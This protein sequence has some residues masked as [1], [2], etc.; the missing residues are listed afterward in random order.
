MRAAKAKDRKKSWDG[1]NRDRIKQTSSDLYLKK[2]DQRI[3]ETSAYRKKNKKHLMS[4]Q[5]KREKERRNTDEAYHTA[6]LLR[7]RLRGALSRGKKAKSDTTMKLVGA[8]PHEV[9]DM[10]RSLWDRRTKTYE[11]DHVF[12]FGLYDMDSDADQHK[13]M[14][15]SN[16]QPL[17]M[18][19][20]RSKWES[21]PTKA[22]AA[23][24]ER[25]AWP[26]GVTE[27]MLPDTYDGW[28]TP[29]RM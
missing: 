15:I 9:K 7:Q 25:W 12:P 20:N 24:V 22:M 11:I 28:A 14:H 5:I 18:K 29:M 8:K 23:K 6:V 21:L 4:K 10:L 19:E 13:V 27:D 16:L 2:R 26:L 17:T 3:A 1:S